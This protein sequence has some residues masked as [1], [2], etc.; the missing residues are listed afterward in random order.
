MLVTDW[1]DKITGISYNSGRCDGCVMFQLCRSVLFLRLVGR[2]P[3]V[4][5]K[6]WTAYIYVGD[7]DI[8]ID[9]P[10][11]TEAEDIVKEMGSFEEDGALLVTVVMQ[12]QPFRNYLLERIA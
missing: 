4:I 9:H 3:V 11:H 6:S 2:M 12:M 5:L 8:C 1:P 7:N 10:Q